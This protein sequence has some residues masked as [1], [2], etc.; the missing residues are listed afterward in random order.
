MQYVLPAIFAFTLAALPASVHADSL[1]FSPQTSVV[2]PG[3]TF[4]VDINGNNFGYV[5]DGGGFNLSWNPAIVSVDSLA[6]D[7]NT[8]DFVQT[9]SNGTL[10]STAG[11]IT[12]VIFNDFF[13][14]N[15]GNFPIAVL[16]L[17]ALKLGSTTLTLTG[18]A[19][20]KFG[21]GGNQVFPM[22]NAGEVNVVST[23]P[24]PSA[25]WLFTGGLI[26][27]L[28]FMRRG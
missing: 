5:L 9:D 26:G 24:L 20:F 15:Q 27:L 7:S 25:A 6:V 3:Q 22:L 11:T 2:T 12:N 23:I 18:S 13:N 17:T 16:T 21:S 14:Q 28:G 1:D 4:Q 10:N 19:D 8:W